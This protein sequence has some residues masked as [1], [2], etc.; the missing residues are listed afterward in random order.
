[1]TQ[2]QFMEMNERIKVAN[3][4]TPRASKSVANLVEFAQFF[5]GRATDFQQTFSEGE[6]DPSKINTFIESGKTIDACNDLLEA[7]SLF[8]GFVV[9]PKS[10]SAAKLLI[11]LERS[12]EKANISFYMNSGVKKGDRGSIRNFRNEMIRLFSCVDE[13]DRSKAFRLTRNVL[14]SLCDVIDSIYLVGGK[15]A[16]FV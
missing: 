2:E 4:D 9:K 14:Y 12:M 16:L 6:T 1:M 7:L 8:V 15:S 3:N 5:K 13:H 10:Q 11:N